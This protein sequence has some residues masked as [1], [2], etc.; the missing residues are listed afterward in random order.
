MAYRYYRYT[1]SYPLGTDRGR[2]PTLAR[3]ERDTSEISDNYTFDTKRYSGY[4]N[5]VAVNNYSGEEDYYFDFEAG[6]W[7]SV[8]DDG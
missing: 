7:L 1:T 3:F 4:V 5:W 2:A 8:S 6:T